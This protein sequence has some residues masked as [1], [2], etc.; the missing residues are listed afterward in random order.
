MADFDI[1]MSGMDLFRENLVK[2]ERDFPKDAQKMLRKVGTKAA[3]ITKKK[4]RQLVK[5]NSGNYQRSIKHG[6]VWKG[7]DGQFVIRVYASSKIA[8]H[9]HLIENGHRIVGKDGKEHGFQHGYKVFEKA[10]KE[11]DSQFESI[12]VREFEKIMAK[13]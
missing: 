13:L 4:A 11:M 2:L 12:L 3:T 1:D 8:P 5:K 6:K 9:A 10:V 7:A